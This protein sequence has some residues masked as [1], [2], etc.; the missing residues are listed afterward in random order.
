MSEK[1]EK[2]RASGFPS[3]QFTRHGDGGDRVTQRKLNRNMAS[4]GAPE[5]TNREPRGVA[6]SWGNKHT[7]ELTL[8][9]LGCHAL[10]SKESQA[11]GLPITML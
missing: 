6:D 4:A 5:A 3:C 7:N 8:E 11:T 2:H 1:D 10:A 9:P